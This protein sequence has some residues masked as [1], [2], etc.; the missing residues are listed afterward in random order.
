MRVLTM[1]AIE[2]T[3]SACLSVRERDC[4]MLAGERWVADERGISI[5][6]DALYNLPTLREAMGDLAWTVRNEDRQDLTRRMHGLMFDVANG[7]LVNGYASD[8]RWM[9]TRRAF[10]QLCNCLR[11]RPPYMAQYLLARPEY[12]LSEEW[13][14]IRD[15]NDDREVVLRLRRPTTELEHHVFATV[16]PSYVKYDPDQLADDLVSLFDDRADEVRAGVAYRGVETTIRMY[17]LSSIPGIFGHAYSTVHSGDDGSCSVQVTSGVEMSSGARFT[18][19]RRREIQ[20]ILHRGNPER[21]RDELESALDAVDRHI[22]T[23]VRLWGS[24]DASPLPADMESVIAALCGAVPET[25][26][27][28]WLKLQEV[29][30]AELTVKLTEVWGRMKVEGTAHETHAGLAHVFAAA[31]CQ[32]TWPSEV[33]IARLEDAAQAILAMELKHLSKIVQPPPEESIGVAPANQDVAS[34]INDRRRRA[35]EWRMAASLK[36]LPADAS[37]LAAERADLLDIEADQIEETGI[38]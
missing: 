24:R 23:W 32:T 34:A 18:A 26:K 19:T 13:R 25:E 11:N 3:R 8:E 10:A 30:A 37:E 27:R 15:N 33:V 22:D 7:N 9:Y 5:N 14:R 36:E 29:G 12:V 21:F 16:T 28:P 38:V 35:V 1:A 20:R 17:S 31:A 6:R 4:P 2:A